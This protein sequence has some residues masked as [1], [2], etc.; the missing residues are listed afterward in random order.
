MESAV[1]A[2]V[3]GMYG[4]PCSIIK[5]VT[6]FADRDGK[7]LVKK[8]IGPVSEKISRIVLKEFKK[9]LG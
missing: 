3:A 5:G 2:R 1:I 9:R 7:E 4:V 8:T 6:D